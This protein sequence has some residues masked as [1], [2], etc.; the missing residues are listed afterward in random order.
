METIFSLGMGY[1]LGSLHPAA[2]VGKRRNVDLKQEGTKNLGATN[3][4]MVLGWSAGIFVMVFDILKS[5]LAGKLAQILFPQLRIAGMLACIGAIIGHCFPV[6]LR[7]QGGRGLSAFGG[8]VIYYN[9]WFVPIILVSALALMLL[10]D[11]GVAFPLLVSVL[12]PVLVFTFGATVPEVLTAAAAG[13]LLAVMHLENLKK[14][15]AKDESMRIREP[16]KEKLFHR[17]S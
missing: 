3:T 8:L 15:F 1:L 5:F 11:C 7:F 9:L 17:V 13:T 6:F 14:A 10:L 12:F 4:M 16:L 2:L